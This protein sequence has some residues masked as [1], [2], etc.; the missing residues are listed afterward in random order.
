MRREK[1]LLILSLVRRN[2]RNSLTDMSKKTRIPVTTIYDKLKEYE[3]DIIKKHTALID[4]KQL[5]FDVRSQILIKLENEK[6]ELCRVYLLREEHINSVYRINNGFDFMV[7]GVFVNMK[8][9]NDFCE[10]LEEF[11]VVDL[12]M[13]FV[14][15]D[16]K[17][18]EFLAY[19]ENVG[20]QGLSFDD[21]KGRLG[22]KDQRSKLE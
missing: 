1:E 5:G 6:R 19:K 22:W 17:R 3:G 20:I 8:D 12:K 16:L 15:E 18:E 10:S 21:I 9:L 4:F 11:G 14:L 2:A 13:F 7:E